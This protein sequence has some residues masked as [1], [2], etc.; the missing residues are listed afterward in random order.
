MVLRAA[1]AL[2]GLLAVAPAFA[3]PMEMLSHLAPQLA[4]LA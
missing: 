1:A 4:A 3:E 2:A